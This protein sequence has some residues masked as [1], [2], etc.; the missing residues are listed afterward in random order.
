VNE[1]R[2]RLRLAD[3]GG[4]KGVVGESGHQ[5]ERPQLQGAVE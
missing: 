1:Q 4:L 5:Q 2:H 3:R